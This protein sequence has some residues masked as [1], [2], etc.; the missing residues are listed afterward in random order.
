MGSFI[1]ADNLYILKK[2]FAETGIDEILLAKLLESL[3]IEG[4]LQMFEGKSTII[5]LIS[6]RPAAAENQPERQTNWE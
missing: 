3:G 1:T 4:I 5:W 6:K 2:F